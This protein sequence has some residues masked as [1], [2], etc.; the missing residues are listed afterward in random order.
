M[1]SSAA[2]SLPSPPPYAA[3]HTIV[4][5]GTTKLASPPA[6]PLEGSRTLSSLNI[7]FSPPPSLGRGTAASSGS[8]RVPSP[9]SPTYSLQSHFDKQSKGTTVGPPLT[10]SSSGHHEVI[11]LVCLLPFLPCLTFLTIFA[12]TSSL[13]RYALTILPSLPTLSAMPTYP[14]WLHRLQLNFALIMKSYQHNVQATRALYDWKLLTSTLSCHLEE[15]KEEAVTSVSQVGIWIYGS[16]NF[17]ELGR[18]SRSHL[19]SATR[20]HTYSARSVECSIFSLY[21]SKCRTVRYNLTGR[22][23]RD[24]IFYKDHD[25]IYCEDDYLYCGFQRTAEKCEACGHIISQT[26]LQTLGKS[27]HPGCFRCCI[28]TKC[29]DQVPFTVDENGQVYCVPD[30]HLVHAPICAACAQPILPAEGS[31]DVLRV[32]AQDKEFHVECY[33]CEDCKIQLGND[34]DNCWYPLVETLEGSGPTVITRTHLLCLQC[35]LS[36][37]GASPAAGQRFEVRRNSN[38]SLSSD[39]GLGSGSGSLSYLSSGSRV[40]SP[41]PTSLGIASIGKP[42][43]LG[44]SR[45]DSLRPWQQHV[46]PT[47]TSNR[48]PD[49]PIRAL[50]MNSS[51]VEYLYYSDEFVDLEEYESK[52]SISELTARQPSSHSNREGAPSSASSQLAT[53]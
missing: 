5:V 15:E 23:L 6:D 13:D 45:P 47:T 35:H 43:T 52:S 33:R 53:V 36:R 40:Y 27:Y 14:R 7:V 44:P 32:V 3:R 29:L 20:I 46:Q 39:Q 12:A 50:T 2:P 28:C 49:S 38:G 48:R 31:D 19:S 37:I 30:Y 18:R 17:R 51:L 16:T 9:L 26:I 21:Q 1:K 10:R 8:K 24:K 41:T 11:Y 42:S 22:T 34:S 4:N 25:K